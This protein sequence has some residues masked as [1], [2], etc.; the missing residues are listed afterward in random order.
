MERQSRV[1]MRVPSSLLEWAKQYFR[2]QGSS[3]TKD[4]VEHLQQLKAK[5]E[6]ERDWDE[7]VVPPRT[8]PWS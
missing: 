1:N 7:L 8:I 2:E 3:L 6:A 4:Y 5:K